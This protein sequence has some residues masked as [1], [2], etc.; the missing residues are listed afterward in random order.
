MMTKDEIK[1]F[2][3]NSLNASLDNI[4]AQMAEIKI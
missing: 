3:M 2:T 4:Y 1:A